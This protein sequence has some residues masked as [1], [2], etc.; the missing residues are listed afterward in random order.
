MTYLTLLKRLEACGSNV[1]AAEAAALCGKPRDWC[2]LHRDELLPPEIEDLLRRREAGEPLQYILGEA[3][4]Y[5]YAFRVTPACLIPQ[6][7]TEHVVDLALQRLRSRMRILDLCTGS[8][9]IAISILKENTALTA[10]AIDISHDALQI[11][12]LNAERLSVS[13]R[14]RFHECDALQS[15]KIPALIAKAD[16]VVSNPPYIDSDVIDTLSPEVR[17]EPRLALDGGSDGMLFYRR[18]ILDY[19][20]HLRPDAYMLLEI[21]YDQADRIADLCKKAGVSCKLHRDFGGNIRVAE[22]SRN[23]TA[24]GE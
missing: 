24:C 20:K 1:P 10:D 3:W 23:E 15:K 2:L 5:G 12:K 6:P 13:D 7:D 22:I 21:G 4:F 16:V 9:C 18:F 11:A 17:H 14:I 19:T 8:G